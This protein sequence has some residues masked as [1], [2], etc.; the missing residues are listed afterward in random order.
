[1][2][3]K[4]ALCLRGTVSIGEGLIPLRQLRPLL[5]V[6]KARLSGP[7]YQLMVILTCLPYTALGSQQSCGT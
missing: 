6:H 3:C 2:L 4:L 5:R 7:S 1:M